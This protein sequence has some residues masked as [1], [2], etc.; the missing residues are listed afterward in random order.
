MKKELLFVVLLLFCVLCACAKKA[1]VQQPRVQATGETLADLRDFPQNLT[2]FAKAAGGNKLLLGNDVQAAKY[3]RF[4]SIYFGPWHMRKNSINRREM[5]E[6][7]VRRAR[8]YKNNSVPWNQEEWDAM[9]TRANPGAFPSRAAPAI[10]LRAT[11]LREMP[12]HEPRFSKPTPDP[13]ADPFDYNQYSLL[14]PGT[15][16]FITHTTL[17]GTWHYVECPIA[18]GWVDATDVALADE[19]FRRLWQQSGNYAAFVKD[20]V[21]LPGVGIKGSDGKGGIGTVLPL[22]AGRNGKLTVLVPIRG[23]NGH[24]DSA[25]ITLAAGM[26][27]QM[28]MPMTAANVAA[29]GNEMM[30]QH[31]GWGGMLGLRDCSAMLRDLFTPFGIWLA[32]NS[33]AQAKSGNVVSLSGM[34]QAEK[35]RTILQKGLPFLSLVGMRGHITLYVGEWRKRPAIFHNAWGVRVIRDDNDDERFVIGKAVVTSIAPGMEL[36]NLYRPVTFVDRIRTLTTIRGK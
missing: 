13:N 22:V 12:T 16:I 5:A 32:R 36:E 9:R 19:E 27:V 33:G 30:G 10:T 17:D 31:Y 34:S 21:N 14:P 15:P 2:V 1:P 8:G 7:F 29:V 18:G 24:A 4:I 20:G 11:D 26:A 23:K 35:E 25:E 3:Q 28:P 6:P